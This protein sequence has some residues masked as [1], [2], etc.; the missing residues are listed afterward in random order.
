MYDD[1]FVRQ[2]AVCFL[3]VAIQTFNQF[4]QFPEIEVRSYK[5]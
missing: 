4:I 2:S 5:H 3:T 1:S